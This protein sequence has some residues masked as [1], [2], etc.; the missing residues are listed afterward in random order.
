MISSADFTVFLPGGGRRFSTAAQLADLGV[1]GINLEDG[2]PGGQLRPTAEHAAVIR[3]VTDATPSLF[4]NARTDTYWLT[5]GADQERLPETV[6]R[7]AAYRDAG[8]SGVFTPGLFDPA[9]IQTVSTTVALPL[10]VLWQPGVSLA[11]LGAAGVVRVST[12]STLYRHALAAALDA[13]AAARTD[14]APTTRP[15]DYQQLQQ[16]LHAR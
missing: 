3:A 5:V 13:A 6:R 7:L 2:R 15:I 12:G 14:T 4:V 1:A 10:N 9:A 11:N 8:A 16:H